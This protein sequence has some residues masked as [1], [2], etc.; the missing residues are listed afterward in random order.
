MKKNLILTAV[1]VLAAGQIA[2][3]AGGSG[4]ESKPR[5]T[6][7]ADAKKGAEAA[8]K[9][10]EKGADASNTVSKTIDAFQ[11][12]VINNNLNPQQR[13]DLGANATT[14]PV[15]AAIVKNATEQANKGVAVEL[16]GERVRGLSLL[17]GEDL[18]TL[19]SSKDSMLKLTSKD[20]IVAAYKTLISDAGEVA[21]GWT[22][23]LRDN[24]TYLLK[25]ANDKIAQGLDIVTAMTE[26]NDALARD[27]KV[28][29]DLNKVVEF[30]KK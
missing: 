6:E 9:L 7:A 16:Q 4:K 5:G 11:K 12:S 28:K 30:C 3:A 18:Q 22:P 27:K 21:S 10:G 8:G 20:K 17:K 1:A 13:V 25:T 29:L 2:Q 24:L 19:G 26:A 15:V 23:E 14:S